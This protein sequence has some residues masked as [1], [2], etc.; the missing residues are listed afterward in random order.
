M[1]SF[2]VSIS[3]DLILLLCLIVYQSFTISWCCTMY[4]RKKTDFYFA[5]AL[6]NSLALVC[7]LCHFAQTIIC[8]VAL[9]KTPLL[10]YDIIV[11]NSLYTPTILGQSS[12]YMCVFLQLLFSAT[13]MRLLHCTFSM[14]RIFIPSILG[15]CS[16][17]LSCSLLQFYFAEFVYISSVHI[18]VTN[19][20]DVFLDFIFMSTLHRARRS[21]IEAEFLRKA[22]TGVKMRAA[23]ALIIIPLLTVLMNIG[24]FSEQI[25]FHVR[26]FVLCF[27]GWYFGGKTVLLDAVTVLYLDKKRME[28]E[29]PLSLTQF[30]PWNR[31][32]GMST[33][34]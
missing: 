11:T 4:S 34:I 12:L 6:Q 18:F 2:A 25:S 21:F 22:F 10:T 17:T 19:C 33:P 24:M 9:G 13:R 26:T 1:S 16:F 14:Q 3:I 23:A 30:T 27:F 5:M 8:T 15:I 31:A 29:T 32:K 20:F 28:A 7:F